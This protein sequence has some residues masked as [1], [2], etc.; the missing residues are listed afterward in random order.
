MS[1]RRIYEAMKRFTDTRAAARAEYLQTMQAIEDAKGTKYYSDREAAAMEKRNALTHAARRECEAELDAAFAAMSKANHARKL[2]APTEEQ[3][4]I[5]RVLAMRIDKNGETKRSITREELDSA[6]NAMEGNPLALA[7]LT[8]I[9]QRA[10]AHRDYTADAQE[11]SIGT[12]DAQLHSL[13]QRC[14]K[15]LNSAAQPAPLQSAIMSNR[16]YGTPIDEDTLPQIPAFESEQQFSDFMGYGEQLRK[17]T[18]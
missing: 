2:A 8:E 4:R 16:R 13:A 17:A 9:A 15:I 7:T 10:G 18:S 12:A 6:A 3:E 14:K 5:L 1:T 11:I